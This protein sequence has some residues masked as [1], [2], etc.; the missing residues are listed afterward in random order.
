MYAW[1][2]VMI[3]CHY[4]GNYNLVEYLVNAGANLNLTHNGGRT[5][6]YECKSSW[7]D[8]AT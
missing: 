4:S 6:L 8:P 1:T 3:A 5:A 7:D 2:A